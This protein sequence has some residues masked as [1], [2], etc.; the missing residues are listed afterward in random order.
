LKNEELKSVGGVPDDR[1]TGDYT[2][3]VT[4]KHK[5]N[6]KNAFGVLQRVADRYLRKE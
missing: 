6:V 2:D 3:P 4:G 1:R 5:E